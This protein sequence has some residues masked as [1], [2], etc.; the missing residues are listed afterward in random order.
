MGEAVIPKNSDRY[1][2]PSAV[3]K[4]R[5]WAMSQAIDYGKVTPKANRNAATWGGRYEL[6]QNCRATEYQ[7]N[8][9]L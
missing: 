9:Q 1:L 5:V 4:S 7:E 3:E 2:G 6:Q 8:A